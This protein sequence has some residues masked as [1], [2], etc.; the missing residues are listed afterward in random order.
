M[1]EGLPVA[2]KLRRSLVPGST[3]R[4]VWSGAIAARRDEVTRSRSIAGAGKQSL[5][6]FA[7]ICL[8][9]IDGDG[10]DAEID[11]RAAIDMPS[12]ATP[13]GYRMMRPRGQKG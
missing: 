12:S 2:D 1:A 13:E 8:V 6:T 9:V 11:S 4:S 5:Q 10:G 3:T 7:I